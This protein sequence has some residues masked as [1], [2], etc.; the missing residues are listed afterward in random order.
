V[1]FAVK[2]EYEIDAWDDPG[3]VV[4]A[5]YD[6]VNDPEDKMGLVISLT[7]VAPWI[8]SLLWTEESDEPLAAVFEDV[9]VR[10]YRWLSTL[11]KPKFVHLGIGDTSYLEAASA[12]LLA[13]LLED[14]EEAS[15]PK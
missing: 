13:A 2:V 12:E 6:A 15:S 4:D 8:I 10:S 11:G 5:V 3:V 9:L 1:Q 14:S 7:Q